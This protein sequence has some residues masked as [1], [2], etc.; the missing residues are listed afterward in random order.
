MQIAVNASQRAVQKVAHSD[1]QITLENVA[2]A[3]A[4]THLH[5]DRQ[6]ERRNTDP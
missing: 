2:R 6:Q 4:W 1:A 5:F 3:N